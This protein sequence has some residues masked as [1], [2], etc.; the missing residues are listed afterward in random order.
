M[1]KH[2]DRVSTEIP[3]KPKKATKRRQ[4]I[5]ESDDENDCVLSDY[6]PPSRKRAK[7]TPDDRSAPKTSRKKKPAQALPLEDS[8]D[9]AIII[10]VKKKD[11]ADSGMLSLFWARSV[12]W[13][14]LYYSPGPN[15]SEEIRLFQQSSRDYEGH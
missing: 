2:L 3:A 11:K 8:D 10:V 14:T 15:G 12:H 6:M 4:R 9:S 5:T 1:I 7:V 13:L